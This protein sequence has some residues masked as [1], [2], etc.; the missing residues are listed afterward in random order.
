M[1]N[2]IQEISM[3]LRG[4]MGHRNFEAMRYLNRR[5]NLT[6]AEHEEMNTA[7]RALADAVGVYE[8]DQLLLEWEKAMR[9]QRRVDDLSKKRS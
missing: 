5:E 8:G 9:Y 4:L 3:K 1:K 6:E 7:L 2:A